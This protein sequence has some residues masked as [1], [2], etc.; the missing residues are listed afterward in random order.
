MASTTRSIYRSLL[1]ELPP[2]TASPKQ[3]KTTP[4][5]MFLR[6]SFQSRDAVGRAEQI[7]DYL[8]AQRVYVALLER[9]NPNLRIEEEDRVKLSARRVGF[10]MPKEV[11]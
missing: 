11:K 10:E 1:R 2:L 8:K 9:Y 5:H 3:I 7:R 6:K 4:A